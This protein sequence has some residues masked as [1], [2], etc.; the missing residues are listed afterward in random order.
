MHMLVGIEVSWLPTHEA[1]KV[2]ELAGDFAGNSM[3]VVDW[4]NLV[5][6]TP[7]ALAEDPFAQIHVDPNRQA[8]VRPS[9]RGSWL[10]RRPAH[11]QARAG[12]DATLVRSYDALV[13]ATAK[14]KIVGVD[15]QV[16]RRCYRSPCGESRSWP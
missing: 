11:H 3:F 6:R 9:V 7:R 13:Y 10:D 14:P 5:E 12:H 4:N 2:D 1:P 8:W 15:D 16:G